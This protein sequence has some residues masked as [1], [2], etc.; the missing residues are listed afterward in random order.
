MRYLL[1]LLALI[2]GLLV[3]IRLSPMDPGRWHLDPRTA[4]RPSTPNAWIVRD[5]DG[6]APTARFATSRAETA[7][8]LEAVIAA[9]PRVA[10][11]AGSAS[12]GWVTYVQRSRLL[13][14]PDAIS[15]RLSE[16]GGETRVE[17]FSR[18]RFGYG[19]GGVNRARVTRWIEALSAALAS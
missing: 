7:R 18:S 19:D 16:E 15:I 6:D 5:A 12:E 4:P 11:L 13:G 14:Y 10:R 2:A 17:I 8:A 3:Y 1:I 9:A